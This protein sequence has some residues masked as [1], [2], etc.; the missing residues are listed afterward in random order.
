MRITRKM[1]EAY[2]AEINKSYVISISVRYFNG[3]TH[4]YNGGQ[5]L[6]TGSTPACYTALSIFMDGLH[7]GMWLET[8]SEVGQ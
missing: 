1:L 8:N 6:Y 3:Y 2:I 7:T 4:V 5:T